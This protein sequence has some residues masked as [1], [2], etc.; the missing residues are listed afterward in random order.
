MAK[1]VHNRSNEKNHKPSN[2]NT[3]DNEFLKEKSISYMKESKDSHLNK[4]Q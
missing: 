4:I 2:I 3:E 1:I